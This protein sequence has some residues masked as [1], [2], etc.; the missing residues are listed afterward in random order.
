MSDFPLACGVFSMRKVNARQVLHEFTDIA[1]HRDNVCSVLE[2]SLCMPR[3]RQITS[4]DGK[5][6]QAIAE[7]RYRA[8]KAMLLQVR[9]ACLHCG[10]HTEL[11][12]GCAFQLS[13][14]RP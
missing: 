8:A 11:P 10:S 13:L 6:P 14:H 4:A 5:N 2:C 12:A 7:F 1:V 3:K 9:A